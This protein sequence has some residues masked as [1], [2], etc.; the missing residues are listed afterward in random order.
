[1]LYMRQSEYA[2]TGL[3]D[4][5]N[6]IPDTQNKIMLEI[7]SHIGESAVQF[8]TRFKNI[9]C[10]DI[11]KN[12]EYHA[13]FFKNIEPYKNIDY[14]KIHSI[15]YV[16]YVNDN[17]FDFIY[18]DGDHEYNAVK[19]DIENWVPKVKKGGYIGG[20]DYDL[21]K[22]PGV[23]KAVDEFQKPDMVFKDTSWIIKK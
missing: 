17:Y 8:A 6:Y 16:K 22:F 4:L 11:W 10:I 20:H 15:D 21:I 3:I 13:E 9:I 23:I 12:K 7:G 5:I 18:I 14:V 19:Y 1:M 2:I